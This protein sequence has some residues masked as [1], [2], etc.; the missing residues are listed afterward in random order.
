MI[1]PPSA[2]I[3]RRVGPTAC[4][5][6]I[7]ASAAGE[8]RRARCEPPPLPPRSLA[9]CARNFSARVQD[10]RLRRRLA[11][12]AGP[13]L[14]ALRAAGRRLARRSSGCTRRD[15][16]LAWEAQ[17]WV[18][19]QE[20][21]SLATVCPSCPQRQRGGRRWGA[22]WTACGRVVAG[23]DIRRRRRESTHEQLP[24]RFSE[25][26]TLWPTL[27]FLVTAVVLAA[28]LLDRSE[29]ASPLPA[30]P[31][32]VNRLPAELTSLQPPALPVSGVFGRESEL[33]R[34]RALLAKPDGSFA[35]ICGAGGSGKT[36]VAAALAAAAEQARCAHVLGALAGPGAVH[37]ADDRRGACLR[38]SR[39][40]G[41]RGSAEGRSVADLVWTQL[42]AMPG[43]LLIIG[44]VDRPAALAPPG[45]P[46]HDYRGWIRP[47]GG[48][49]SWSPAGIATSAPGATAPTC[50]SSDP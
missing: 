26:W 32:L 10:R 45:E 48:G 50:L 44:S 35:V 9:R 30:P 2:D 11:G 28:V 38:A 37:R 23:G 16:L 33:T 7:V 20:A 42:A 15:A 43:W 24:D 8:N 13:V 6:S 12:R 41:R 3:C 4:H 47:G 34:L 25:P 19:R 27:A 22:R 49:C 29:S 14:A 21:C 5:G 36:T 46:L 39:R 18:G 31:P 17:A 1:S 40:Q